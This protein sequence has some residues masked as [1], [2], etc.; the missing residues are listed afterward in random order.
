MQANFF[1]FAPFPFKYQAQVY[2]LSRENKTRIAIATIIGLAFFVLGCI[3]VFNGASNYFRNKKN[4]E[5]A[6]DHNPHIQKV[7]EVAQNN[8]FPLQPVQIPN[9]KLVNFDDLRFKFTKQMDL[10]MGPHLHAYQKETLLK[11]FEQAM[12]TNRPREKL[13]ELIDGMVNQQYGWGAEKAWHIKKNLLEVMPITDTPEQTATIAIQKIAQ[14]D[15]MVCFYKGGLTE[16]LGN[17]ALCPNKIKI[18]GKEFACTEAAF[19]WR[20]YFL[21]AQQNNRRDLLNDLDGFFVCNGEQAFQKRQYLDRQYPQVFVA[22]WQNGVRVQVMWEV[23]QAKFQQ[24]P[25]FKILLDATGKAY[26]LEHNQVA[27]RDAYWSD[28]RTGHGLNML[29]KMLMAIRDNC[30]CPPPADNHDLNMRLQFAAR[31][32]QGLTYQI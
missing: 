26:L 8:L 19:Q 32:N 12:Q 1:T 18:W 25:E 13:D 4:Q 15:G 14:Q 23:L 6:A 28:D 16:F 10:T 24:N 9:Q 20:K 29:G 11:L 3:F 27:G 2:G 7:N 17:F 21:A 30:L 31:A 5:L 22:G